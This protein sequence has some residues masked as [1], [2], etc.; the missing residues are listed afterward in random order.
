MVTTA[1]HPAY[2]FEGSITAAVRQSMQG[3]RLPGDTEKGE[4]VVISA[5]K[6]AI[7]DA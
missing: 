3:V 4:Q 2:A 6:A 7:A 1:P 5:A